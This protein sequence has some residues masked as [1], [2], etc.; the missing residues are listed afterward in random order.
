MQKV[1]CPVPRHCTSLRPALQLPAL[2][3]HRESKR[4]RHCSTSSSCCCHS[5]QPVGRRAAT[6]GTRELPGALA[7]VKALEG[8]VVG[9]AEVK[10]EGVEL[11]KAALCTGASRSDK[12]LIL[13][14][15]ARCHLFIRP[16][17]EPR[18]PGGGS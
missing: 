1:H 9:Q 18:L 2:Q 12:T 14:W 10:A 15:S 4:Q 13:V 7:V 16:E 11:V 3:Q 8:D 17:K 5:H 6:T